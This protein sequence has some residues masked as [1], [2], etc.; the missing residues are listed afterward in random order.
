MDGRLALFEI[1][2]YSEGHWEGDRVGRRTS[3]SS[4][5]VIGGTAPSLAQEGAGRG[6]RRTATDTAALLCVLLFC[7]DAD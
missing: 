7:A 1:T 3:A 5:Y 2:N 6:F 4:T